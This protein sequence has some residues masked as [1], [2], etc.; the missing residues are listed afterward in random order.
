MNTMTTNTSPKGS[1]KASLLVL[2][3]SAALC[4]LGLGCSSE[5]GTTPTCKP[6]VTADGHDKVDDGCNPFATCVI[7][8][9]AAPA[10]ECCK[11]FDEGTYEREACLYGYGAGPEP[12]AGGGPN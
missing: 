8:D 6:D 10:T 11:G 4:A 1:R 7:D 9:Q 5:E 2:G 3:L 12:G